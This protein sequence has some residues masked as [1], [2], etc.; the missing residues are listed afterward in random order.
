MAKLPSFQFYPG[1]WQGSRWVCYDISNGDIIPRKPGCYVIYGDNE[2]IYIGQAANVGIRILNHK[3]RLGWGSSVITPWGNFK[4][5]KVKV[6]FSVK[7][8][9]WAMRELRLIAKLQ[10]KCNCVG[11]K[12][13]RRKSGKALHGK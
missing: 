4:D 1:D 8:G 7:Y 12:N 11:T 2:L 5:V 10:P 9:D 13:R 3:I 6:H